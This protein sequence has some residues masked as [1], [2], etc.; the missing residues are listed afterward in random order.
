[1]VQAELTRRVRNRTGARVNVVILPWYHRLWL[2][3]TQSFKHKEPQTKFR[4]ETTPV[5]RVRPE[6]IRR[7]DDAPKL[8]NPSGWISEG[9]SGTHTPTFKPATPDPHQVAYSS[10]S[11]PSEPTSIA[12][13]V[14]LVVRE[15]LT[16][17]SQRSD[18]FDHLHEKR[19]LKP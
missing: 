10:G 18:P 3:F 8:V 13:E 9:H 2:A 19:Y 7:M 16:P 14:D 1:M 12:D 11:A 15:G 6:M 4:E 17:E 5:P